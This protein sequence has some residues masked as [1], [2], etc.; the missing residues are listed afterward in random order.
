MP[1]LLPVLVALHVLPGVFWAGS[2]FVLARTSAESVERLAYPQIGAA[3]VTIV[4]GAILWNFTHGTDFLSSERILALGVLSAL[5]AAVL[6]ASSLPIVGRLR[7]ADG[8]V[9][10]SLRARIARRQ[11]AAGGLLAVTVI[12]M[13]VFRYV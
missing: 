6:Q 2:T 4:A 13:V 7:S 5:I 10:A 9:T 1:L 11:R 8:R 12:C 3:F